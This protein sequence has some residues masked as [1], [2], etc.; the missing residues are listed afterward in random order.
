MCLEVE[1]DVAIGGWRH[2]DHME[3]QT[4]STREAEA[5]DAGVRAS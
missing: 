2:D 3:C 1:D 4:W 5:V